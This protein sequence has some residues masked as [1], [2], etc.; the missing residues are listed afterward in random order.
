MSLATILTIALTVSGAA[1]H[2]DGAC[3]QTN[4]RAPATRLVAECTARAPSV[5]E[6]FSGPVLQVLDGRTVC[7]AVGPT[8]DQWIRVDLADGHDATPRSA[9]MQAVFAQRIVCISDRTQGQ[10]V[11]AHCALDGV[12]VGSLGATTSAPDRATAPP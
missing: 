1:F 7:V 6:P 3:L 11:V 10:R 9:M 5:G 8:P 12:S 4:W 2:Q